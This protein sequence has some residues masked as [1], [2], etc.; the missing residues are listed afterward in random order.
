MLRRWLDLSEK[1]IA[2]PLVPVSAFRETS[3][4]AAPAAT[5]L[6][7]RETPAITGRTQGSI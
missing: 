1:T 6:D 3:W 2:A 4:Q 5:A 7:E